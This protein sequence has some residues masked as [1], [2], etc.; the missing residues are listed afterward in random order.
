MTTKE[1][2]RLTVEDA[3]YAVERLLAWQDSEAR[4]EGPSTFAKFLSLTG[5]LE[6]EGTV[7]AEP[8]G[9]LECSLLASAL[10]AWA[11]HP[12]DVRGWLASQGV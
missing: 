8:C 5:N 3:L 2:E 10:E 12:N 11:T 4:N 9:Y 1:Q 7:W 6:Q